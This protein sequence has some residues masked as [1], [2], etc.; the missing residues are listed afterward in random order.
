MIKT[1]A[2]GATPKMS[3]SVENQKSIVF[4]AEEKEAAK[5]ELPEIPPLKSTYPYSIKLDSFRTAKDAQQAVSAYMAKGLSSYWVKV[6]LGSQG[7]WY[8]VFAGYFA[9]TQRAEAIISD[10]KLEGATVKMTRYTAR[11]GNFASQK[12]LDGRKKLLSDKGYSP[13]VVNE[14]NNTFTLYVG[15]FYTRKGAD[16]QATDLSSNGIESQ[17]VER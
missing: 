4:A 14:E 3:V 16:E 17:V 1:E 9:S 15:A 2:P 5:D 11:I 10:H 8:R 13:Y 6:D 7:I 12:T